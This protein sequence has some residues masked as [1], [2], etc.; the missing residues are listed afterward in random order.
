M[1]TGILKDREV[2]HHG[3]LCKSGQQRVYPNQEKCLC[4]Q[5]RSDRADQPDS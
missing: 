1:E 2:N 3:K 4:R 5:I